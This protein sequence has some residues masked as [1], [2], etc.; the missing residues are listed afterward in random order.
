[1]AVV[2]VVMSLSVFVLVFVFAFVFGFALI[3][4]MALAITR[5]VD[6]V[7]PAV[8]HEIHRPAASVVFAAVLAPVLGVTGGHVQIQR[9]L[10]Y[11]HTRGHDPHWLRTDQQRR[12][13][14]ADVDTPEKSGL[15]DGDGDTPI[16][17][18]RG[19]GDDKQEQC[20]T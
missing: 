15:A 10:H 20:K 18:P 11:A 12:R 19:R 8:L 14:I 9:L 6:L 5:H 7:V 16:T 2:L 3:I 13:K 17:G 1:M 4:A